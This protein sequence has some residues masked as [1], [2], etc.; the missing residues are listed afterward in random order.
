MPSVTLPWVQD[1]PFKMQS[2]LFSG[3]RGPDTGDL[4][5][6][7]AIVR[8]LRPVTQHNADTSSDY[9]RVHPMPAWEEVRKELECE[10]T[11]HYFGHLLHTFQIIA[12]Y[13][14]SAA[15]QIPAYDMYSK[16]CELLHLKMESK[17]DM[18]ERLQDR[19]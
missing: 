11:V 17:E 6:I 8:W 19:T 10:C 9:M 12:Y 15:A 4:R 7:K 3:M 2:V 13:H 5:G 1:L 16:M 18:I 14:P